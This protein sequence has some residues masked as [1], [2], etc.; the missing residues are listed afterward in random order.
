MIQLT[1][2]CRT[3]GTYDNMIRATSICIFVGIYV[4]YE[5]RRCTEPGAVQAILYE[6]SFVQATFYETE[7]AR[8]RTAMIVS[9]RLRT[10]PLVRSS[11]IETESLLNA[12]FR[13]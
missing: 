10:T 6:F 11:I 4:T 7:S 8:L 12:L 9:S 5:A 1:I 3:Q 2:I 13:F